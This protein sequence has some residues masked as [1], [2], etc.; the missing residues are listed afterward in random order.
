[1]TKTAKALDF[2]MILARS[3]NNGI[4]LHNSLPWHLPT[5]LKYFNEVTS[6]VPSS[7][8][9]WAPNTLASPLRHKEWDQKQNIVLMGSSTYRSIP[10]KYFPLKNR[11]NFVLS[12]KEATTD[13][14]IFVNSI[15]EF[16]NKASQMN[17]HRIFVV[18]GSQIYDEFLKSYKPNCD[19]IF[20]TNVQKNVECD[21]FF[22]LPDDFSPLYVSKSRCE[23]ETSFDFRVYVRDSFLQEP[24]E[25]SKFTKAIDLYHLSKTPHEEYQYLNILKDVIETGLVKDDRT[26]V[27]TISKFGY[28]MEFDCGETFPLLT[29]KQVFIRGI[30]EELIWFLQGNTDA[31]WLKRKKV[32]IWDG[33]SSKEFLEK[34]NLGHREEGDVGPVYGFQWRHFGAKYVNCHS[35]YS[36]QGVDQIIDVI[37]TIKNNPSSRRLIVSAWNPLDLPLMALPPCHVMS[38]FYVSGNKLNLQMY[39]RSADLGLGVPFNIASYA[40][41]LMLMAKVTGKEVGKFVH[42]LGDAHVYSN[43]VDQLRIQIK[44]TPYAFPSLKIADK[45]DSI[46]NFNY[47][48]L[49]LLNYKYHPKVRMEM[50]V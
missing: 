6:H 25:Y 32:H 40:L 12:R 27:G 50:A 29:T 9:H 21:S 48:D 11:I 28:K 18:G 34:L 49:E 42:I 39:Q 31:N 22:T 26:G 38:Q 37:N 15:E 35:N 17:Y 13:K 19:A 3:L 47:E 45:V 36:G 8:P 23:N 4:G 20:L 5:D 2:S 14:A 16:F 44:R 46:E 1:M 7:D 30:V 43:H 33:N 41:L 24:T 10:D